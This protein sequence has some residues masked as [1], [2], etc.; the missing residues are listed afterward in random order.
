MLLCAC[1]AAPVVPSTTFPTPV[2]RQVPVSIG[3]YMDPTFRDYV[4]QDRPAK[5]VA[6]DVSVGPAS[7]SLFTE[8]LGAQFQSVAVLAAAPSATSPARNV[9][10]VLQPVVQD[11]QIA[12]PK[13]DKDEFHEAWIKYRL[14]LLT[15]QGDELTS[16][17]LAA[18]GKQRS[19]AIGGTNS[20]LT[21]AVREAL[22]D[23]AAG[24]ALL[25]RDGAAFRARL[26]APVPAATT[27]TTVPIGEAQPRVPPPATEG[28]PGST[29][30]PP[31]APSPP[32]RGVILESRPQ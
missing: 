29:R 31:S 5:G 14:R 21:A 27:M 2:L 4:H 12:S 25:F 16:W 11:V 3:L 28:A 30:S 18:Y 24:M 1:S 32:Q 7:H 15:P 26:Q 10:G 19:A 22:R 9:S 8:F 23:A 13:T 6:Q 20:G 17:E